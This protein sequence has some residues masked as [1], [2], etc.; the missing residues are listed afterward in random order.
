LRI[1]D[2]GGTEL[3]L[4]EA[5]G[6]VGPHQGTEAALLRLGL[7][8]LAQLLRAIGIATAARVAWLA[9]IAADEDVMRERRHAGI[10]VDRDDGGVRKRKR[11]SEK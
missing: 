5:A 10:V 11:R 7:E 9:A 8:Q 6:F 4:I 3:A 2:D 1:D